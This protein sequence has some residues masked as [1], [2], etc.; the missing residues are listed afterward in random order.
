MQM[1]FWHKHAQTWNWRTYANAL[2]AQTCIARSSFECFWP[3][4][5]N[6]LQYSLMQTYANYKPFHFILSYHVISYVS[7]HSLQCC[8]WQ[9][10]IHHWPKE[11]KKCVKKNKTSPHP[12]LLAN[13]KS[14]SIALG[15]C[16]LVHSASVAQSSHS[17]K[18]PMGL[19]AFDLSKWCKMQTKKS[20]R[21]MEIYVWLISAS[22]SASLGC[23]KF[24]ARISKQMSIYLDCMYPGWV[25][26]GGIQDYTGDSWC[27]VIL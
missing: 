19:N 4:Q 3:G 16:K 8:E 21:I 2:L 1:H 27:H 25:D 10:Q 11:V 23:G 22:F 26:D 13:A 14:S 18:L 20:W 5:I 6:W 24:P 17:R 9:W 12:N 15:E 7:L